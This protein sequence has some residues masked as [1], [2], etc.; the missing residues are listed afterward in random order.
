MKRF[1]L[2]SIMIGS[3]AS[4]SA[5]DVIVN[6][7]ESLVPAPDPIPTRVISRI[8]FR[9]TGNAS[10]VRIRYSTQ[11]DG[12]VQ[13]VTSLPFFTS[14]N[15]NLDGMFLNLE[16]TPLNYSILTNPFLSA[17]IL[18]DGFLFREAT[19]NEFILNTVTASGN[20]RR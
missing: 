1:I 6:I 3:L 9:V 17:Q 19:S 7:P 15:T 10:S 5:C 18:V 14:F 11:F 16:V 8:E 20:W 13:T 4:I 12:L 2:I